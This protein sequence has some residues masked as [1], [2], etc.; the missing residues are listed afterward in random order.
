MTKN[1]FLIRS[2]N[3]NT[4]EQFRKL[5]KDKDMRQAEYLKHLID[6]LDYQKNLEL[7]IKK[8]IPPFVENGLK[9]KFDYEE[10]KIVQ[11]FLEEVI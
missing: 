2:V 8:M 7:I 3:S 9:V 10:I 11:K 4:M 1:D 5:A 6:N